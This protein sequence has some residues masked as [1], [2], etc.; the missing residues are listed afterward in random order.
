MHVEDCLP[1]EPPS[2]PS[3]ERRMPSPLRQEQQHGEVLAVSSPCLPAGRF[4]LLLRLRS[5]Q[6]QGLQE[7]HGQAPSA[8]AFPEK[9]LL[10]TPSSA[11]EQLCDSGGAFCAYG[12][13]LS[14]EPVELALSVGS[15]R[16]HLCAAFIAH[17][18]AWFFKA[19]G[20][21]AEIRRCCLSPTQASRRRGSVEFG[22]R[23]FAA[24]GDAGNADA[25][26]SRSSRPLGFLESILE[27]PL[28]LREVPSHG[29]VTVVAEG[30]EL[31]I[32]SLPVSDK[33]SFFV[34]SPP[35]LA[36]GGIA[37][38][39]VPLT[40]QNAESQASMPRVCLSSVPGAAASA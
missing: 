12:V 7:Q 5:K 30:F 33:G 34:G 37:R 36:A 32:G 31:H 3:P 6:E 18:A 11:D 20:D 24:A 25:A 19:A 40:H 27:I 2:D 10:A 16:G 39:Y 35:P 1:L 29:W 15:L 14:P 17:A 26:A 28:V 8:E 13:D 21:L 38:L 9:G 23:A 4:A 22:K